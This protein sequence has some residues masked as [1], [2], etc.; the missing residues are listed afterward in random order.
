VRDG[1]T[2][3]PSA[4]RSTGLTLVMR[5]VWLGIALIGLVALV[6]DIRDIAAVT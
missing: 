3:D 5:G 6:N 1:S 4:R 2:R